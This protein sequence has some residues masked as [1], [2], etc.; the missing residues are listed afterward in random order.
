M[1][2]R[3]TDAEFSDI[4]L[5]D[6]GYCNIKLKALNAENAGAH[7]LIISNTV[8]NDADGLIDDSYDTSTISVSIPTIIISKADADRLK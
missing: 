7:L 2:T 5:L 4:V 6:S 8:N 3:L 1:N